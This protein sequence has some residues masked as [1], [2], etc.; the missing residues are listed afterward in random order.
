MS[1]NNDNWDFY[2]LATWLIVGLA[3]IIASYVLNVIPNT[4]RI[5]GGFCMTMFVIAIGF[6][7]IKDTNK[8]IIPFIAPVLVC[9][10]WVTI[11]IPYVVA[12]PAAS[13]YVNQS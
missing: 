8:N 3:M 12:I 10:L 13:I 9:S 7:Y 2:M 5:F 4:L 6:E 11:L 1:T